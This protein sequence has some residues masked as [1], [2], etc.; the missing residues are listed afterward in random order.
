MRGPEPTTPPGIDDQ[1]IAAYAEGKPV[2]AIAGWFGTTREQVERLVAEH[3][4]VPAVAPGMPHPQPMAP[5][6]TAGARRKRKLWPY[7]AA[8][9]LILLVGGWVG[10]LLVDRDDTPATPPAPPPF[11]VAQSSCDPAREGTQITDGGKTLLVD[12][13]GSE[14]FTGAPISA[15]ACVLKHL[16]VPQAVVAHMDSTRALDGRQED[17][18][19]G[20][21]ASWTYHP[22]DGMDLIVRAS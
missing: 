17:T 1:I 22:D 13:K 5:P 15:V 2:D 4:R 18:W 20:Y 11:E 9:V 6:A 3:A 10:T 21:T 8:A 16:N 19:P 14:D 12:S 7:L